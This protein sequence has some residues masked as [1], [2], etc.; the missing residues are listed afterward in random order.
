MTY[1]DTQLHVFDE[2]TRAYSEALQ[3]AVAEVAAA[4]S[5]YEAAIKALGQSDVLGK[6]QAKVQQD[7]PR[8]TLERIWDQFDFNQ[9]GLLCEEEND[10]LCRF[11]FKAMRNYIPRML[12]CMVS[13]VLTGLAVGDPRGLA[14]RILQAVEERSQPVLDNFDP[15][16]CSNWPEVTRDIWRKMDV[17][18][19]GKVEK[20]E[21]IS[22]FLDC[23]G[24]KFLN[25]SF[26]SIFVDALKTGGTPA[27][28]NEVAEMEEDQPPALTLPISPC[29]EG[30]P[31]R[32][33]PGPEEA[34]LVEAAMQ[35]A[36]PMAEGD[37]WYLVAYGWWRYW[38][39][40][41]GYNHLA[42][43]TDTFSDPI[44][45]QSL[46]RDGRLIS[47]VLENT[48]FLLLPRAVWKLLHG[49][50]GGGPAVE[51]RVIVEGVGT[52]AMAKV[53]LHLVQVEV[54]YKNDSVRVELSR[55][56]T[57]QEL[58]D[59]AVAGLPPW[60]E[61]E[62]QRKRLALV[63]SH[64]IVHS[65][66]TLRLSDSGV[67]THQKLRIEIEKEDGT[68]SHRPIILAAAPSY[69]KGFCG[70]TNLGNTCFMNSALQCL[71]NTAPFR[72]FFL[73]KQYHED[74]NRDNPLGNGGELAEAF[75]K[76]L[77]A[78][79]SG[80][81]A[82]VSPSAFKMTLSR[83]APQF[84][85]YQQ[86]DSQELIAF[87]L[88]GIH[89]DLNRV[90]KKE[91]VE[92]KDS[93]GRPDA[94]VADE[95]W[96]GHLRRN[97][98]IV[99]DLF[100]GQL[101]STL[102]CPVCERHSVTF[103][104]FMYL[105]VP[106][107]LASDQ[108][109]GVDIT[110]VPF[111]HPFVMTVRYRCQVPVSASIGKL[112]AILAGHTGTA[113]AALL[114]TDVWSSRVYRL[115][116]EDALVADISATDT[117]VAYECPPLAGPAAAPAVRREKWLRLALRMQNE[118]GFSPN[119]LVLV[120]PKTITNQALYEL[121]AHQLSAILPDW[122]AP[123]PR[124]CGARATSS[125]SSTSV[126][127]GGDGPM[128]VDLDTNGVE[129]PSGSV[130]EPLRDAPSSAPEPAVEVPSSVPEPQRLP[131]PPRWPFTIQW[132]S[133]QYRYNGHEYPD[134]ENT[135]LQYS[136]WGDS[137]IHMEVKFGE[138]WSWDNLWQCSDHTSVREVPPVS[139]TTAER[140]TMTL[141]KCMDMFTT[142][143]QLSEQDTV[144]CSQCK[145][146]RQSFK[147]FGLW[148]LPPVLVVH[149]KRFQYGRS[150]YS[151]SKLDHLIKFP[152][153]RW[154]LSPW[155]VP[156]SPHLQDGSAE[157]EL[158]AISHHSGSLHFGHY[159]AYCKHEEWALYNDS[160]VSPVSE[161]SIQDHG[162]YIL[163]YRRRIDAKS[164]TK[165]EE[166]GMVP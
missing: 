58:L 52:R 117:I 146:H 38:R 142:R 79:W 21:F 158:Y 30:V 1:S 109:R 24:C 113:P 34:V 103:D 93:G 39:Q 126:P 108:Q 60:V 111:A 119:P 116:T 23:T 152:I 136:Y 148:K 56:C 65:N 110:F 112:Q 59:R 63:D 47:T 45:N 51:R 124:D 71:S 25:S 33:A 162:A 115:F 114:L 150:A 91:F 37:R 78:M 66:L 2:L 145:E 44:N 141:D 154:D 90:K 4:G 57:V 14:A 139:P 130:P 41:S 151:G 77:Q 50:Y 89:E 5:S 70:L 133:S 82:S 32:P 9:D 161:E 15:L 104:P 160:M 144:Y 92:V 107:Q 125:S 98:S 22:K 28:A 11:Y 102:E 127:P 53:E 97:Q 36:Q 128:L 62:V 6:V 95:A 13:S 149:L 3:A 153:K 43:V 26:Y 101:K 86:H 132:D 138:D 166:E 55:Q 7:T 105:S 27:V 123:P 68:F 85:G 99:V 54:V 84:S 129:P 143:E 49:W 72:E 19:D 135:D 156:G 73:T 140:G 8:E 131:S 134:N 35:D 122:P 157:Y 12:E 100:Q 16:Q 137:V 155:L 163:F 76:L 121:V 164:D 106:V 64:G 75:A 80:E 10:A 94:E 17:N 147:Q 69:K 96:E 81:Q 165:E 87:L 118:T 74:L 42:I 18:M 20:E 159:T 61:E 31:P 120:V 83:F 67:S 40:Y 88:D 46:L 48:D 29:T